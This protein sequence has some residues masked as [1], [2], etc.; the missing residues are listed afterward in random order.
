VAVTDKGARTRR[1]IVRC[2]ASIVATRGV[3][4]TSLAEVVEAAAVTKGALYFHFPSKEA[5]LFGVEEA[6]QLDSRRL[7]EEVAGEGDPLRRL[8]QLT[9][10]LA[11]RQ[12]SDAL[13]VAHA[14]LMLAGIPEQ[15]QH[16][17]PPGSELTPIHWPAVL[18]DWLEEAD[19]AGM[20]V[21]GHDLSQ[22]AEILDDCIIGIVSASQV[23]PRRISMVRRIAGLWRQLLLPAVATPERRVDLEHCLRKVAE[24]P[25][26]VGFTSST[27]AA[28]PGAAHPCCRYLDNDPRSHGLISGVR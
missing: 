21:V 23:E 24:D 12:L 6:Y 10:V 18:R 4:Q 14:R 8:I 13:A 1:R 5:L 15:R 19:R 20:L 3:A 28:P 11:R 16:D 17:D 9:F 7:V 27:D 2:A 26:T 25:E 22:L